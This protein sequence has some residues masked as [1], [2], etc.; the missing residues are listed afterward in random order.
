MGMEQFGH[1]DHLRFAPPPACRGWAYASGDG[2]RAR[3]G[4]GWLPRRWA[5]VAMMLLGL[6]VGGPGGAAALAMTPPERL[7]PEVGGLL[8][9]PMDTDPELTQESAPYM[10][11]PR[12]KE[13]WLQALEEDEVELRHDTVRAFARAHELGLPELDDVPARLVELLTSDPSVKVRQA[14]A[15][16]LSDFDYRE[17]AEAMV[18][19]STGASKAA[20]ALALE[21]DPTLV[22]WGH[23]PAR[24]AWRQRLENERL[25]LAVRRSA[26]RSL[27]RMGDEA[28]G[29]A[30][31]RLVRSDATPVSLRLD[32]AE[33]LGQVVTSGLL[34][35]AEALVSGSGQL[36]R[37]LAASMLASQEDEAAVELLRELVRDADPGVASVA[38]RSLDQVDRR[39]V[40]EMREELSE[41][42][43]PKVRYRLLQTL[44][45]LP[46]PEAVRMAGRLLDDPNRAVRW[47]AREVVIAHGER[48]ALLE[49]AWAAIDEALAE[50]GP[51]GQEQAALAAGKLAH[52][53]SASAVAELLASPQW[54]VRRAAANAL[55]ELAVPETL[56]A[57]HERFIAL[58]EH[59]REHPDEAREISAL[60]EML[61]LAMA[62]GEMRYAEADAVLREYVPKNVPF[63]VEVRAAAIW[64]LGRAYE[65]SPQPDLVSQ[66]EGRM[67]DTALPDPEADLVR[68]HAVITV[69]RMNAQNSLSTIDAVRESPESPNLLRLACIWAVER[70]TGE[71][72]PGVEVTARRPSWFLEPIDD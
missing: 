16:T 4:G 52:E 71:S 42:D 11:P 7:E 18:A 33:A 25:P 12:L 72:R 44:A 26:A 10:F 68:R 35:P 34:E 64:A 43:E 13:V 1:D 50:A 24:E 56:P 6:V 9:R 2:V 58:T 3:L 47:R 36:E 45:E 21:V 20:H 54:R 60:H 61:A 46:E 37:M 22:R 19:A 31:E 30:L 66:L 15:Q 32:A 53:A 38:L 14:A 29:A 59:V 51:F 65:D 17:A 27:G 57:I 70:M 67:T 41:R 39:A 5:F 63:G 23:E 8:V 62:L 48:E 40:F 69:A 28:A 49:T 55:L